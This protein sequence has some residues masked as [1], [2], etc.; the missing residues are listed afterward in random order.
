MIKFIRNRPWII[1]AVCY[2][3]FVGAWVWLFRV[4][5]ANAPQEIKLPKPA[6]RNH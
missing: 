6:A 1:I 5:L 3:S 4:A 2:L